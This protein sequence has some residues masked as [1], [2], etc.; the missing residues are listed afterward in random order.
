MTRSR[1]VLVF[2][3]LCVVGLACVYAFRDTPRDLIRDARAAGNRE[4][5]IPAGWWP[6]AAKCLGIDTVAYPARVFSRGE[7]PLSWR[8]SWSRGPADGYT[9]RGDTALIWVRAVTDSLVTHEL[10]H[11]AFGDD[12]PANVFGTPTTPSRCGLARPFP[13]ITP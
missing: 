9:V 4:V 11:A 8:K 1:S 10:W 5:F 13:P 2:G 7:L 6:N 3:G 12:H